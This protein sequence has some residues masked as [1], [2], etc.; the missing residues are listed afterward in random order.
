MIRM[1][2]HRC[3]GK[4]CLNG[5]E[6]CFLNIAGIYCFLCL[7]SLWSCQTATT[8]SNFWLQLDLTLQFCITLCLSVPRTSSRVVPS[9]RNL[10]KNVSSCKGKELNSKLVSNKYLCSWYVLIS[11]TYPSPNLFQDQASWEEKEKSINSLASKSYQF[12]CRTSPWRKTKR[13]KF[14]IMERATLPYCYSWTLRICSWFSWSQYST[15]Q[16]N[17]PCPCEMALVQ[18][19]FALTVKGERKCCL[20]LT[21]W[22]R[23][24]HHARKHWLSSG[25]LEKSC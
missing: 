23:R 15:V 11:F 7:K 3:C 16:D 20:V 24:A 10:S 25:R 19:S 4:I 22:Q 18:S 8:L 5:T 21:S 2:V 12:K 14:H 17:H 13:H 6:E 9:S 1:T